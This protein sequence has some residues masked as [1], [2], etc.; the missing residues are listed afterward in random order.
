VVKVNHVSTRD[1]LLQSLI[2]NGQHFVF[3]ADTGSPDNFCTFDVWTRL[4]K[5][6][7][8]PPHSRYTAATGKPLPVRGM[9]YI[10]AKLADSSRSGI[11]EMNVAKCHLNLLGR[12]AIHALGIDVNGLLAKTRSRHPPFSERVCTV[13]PNKPDKALQKACEELCKE[14]PDVFKEELGCLKNFELELKFKPDAKPVFIK[15]RTV[16]LAILEDLDAA[17]EAGIKKGVWELTSFNEWGTP[18]VPVRKPPAPGKSKGD[19]RVCGDYSV[20]INPQLEDHRHPLPLP[21]DLMRK[22]GGGYF[23]T[24]IDLANAYNQIKLGPESQKRLALSTHKGVLLQKRLSFGPKPACSI[25]QELMDKLTRPLRG[26]ATF[27]DDFLVSGT[28]AKDHLQNFRALLQVLRDNGLRA[29]FEKCCFAMPSVE[30]LGHILSHQGIAKGPKVDAVLKMPPPTDVSSLRSFLGSVQFYS[31]FLPNLSTLTE[32][33]IRLTRKDT[34]WT[35]GKEQHDAFRQ[36]KD[37]LSSDT[38]LA[39]YDPSLQIGIST[40]ASEVGIGAVLFHRYRDGSERPIA[41]ASKTLS[42]AQRRY[43]QVQKEALGVI[44]GLKKFH[45]FLFGRQFILITDCKPLVAMFAP[46]KGVPVMAANRLARWALLLSQYDYTVEYRA[47]KDHGNADALSRLPVGDDAIF[48]GEEDREDSNTVC[49]VEGIS[50]QLD[51]V[52]PRLLQKESGKDPI[53]STV[54]RYCKEG[55]PNVLQDSAKPFQKLVDSLSTEN[56]C[57]F[58]GSRIVVPERLRRQV[59][60]LLHL[61]HFGMQRMKQLARSVVYWPHIDDDIERL[62]RECSACQEQQNK[63]PK[64]ANHPWMLPEKPWSRLHVD[65]AI[66][67]M[68]YNW[69][70]LVDAYSKYPCIHPTSSTTAKATMDLLDEDFAHFGYPHTLVSDNATTFLCEEFQAWCKERGITHL[71][72]APYHPATNGAAERLVQSFKQS[73]RKSKLPPKVA[74][75]EF[76]MQYRRTP[77]DSGRSPSE[78]LN[79]RQI[80]TK[81]DALV[82]SPAHVA[83]GRQ[84][85]EAAK[86]Q[87]EETS[88]IVSPVTYYYAVG[89]PCY[90]LYCGP[91]RNKEPRWIPAV[92][93]KVFGSRSV[94]VRVIPRGPTWR[95]HLDQLRPRY[96]TSEDAEPGE[97][98]DIAKSQPPPVAPVPT[99]V[100]PPAIPAKPI[101][102][103]WRLPTTDEYGKHNLRR[104]ARIAAKSGSASGGPSA[105]G[106]VLW[107]RA[108]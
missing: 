92:V 100:Q 104:S 25:F 43:S 91:K 41:Y 10:Q 68:G 22:L 59:L 13:E 39:H 75:R 50:R 80:R 36:L 97:A 79:G 33:L 9:F 94:N 107:T 93:T 35:W 38:V 18:V 101:R 72:G 1:S 44:Y 3:Q 34:P 19:L 52:N 16:P 76:L 54:M 65:H 78:L 12:A 95:R 102:K 23:F 73:L 63:P 66:N 47:T 86:E 87:R 108:M 27:L 105:G 83:Q 11:I 88:H 48:D 67:F 71:S 28:D 21:E 85:K 24:K 51:P 8:Q 49:I 70:V 58:A 2:L 106:E 53:I 90:A 98:P 5:P 61:G 60:D 29:K 31:K 45:H 103:N 7:L 46:T 15:P 4:G 56:G 82:P 81:L 84:A 62:S 14:F 42:P 89:A 74:L 40:D 96:P 32:P 20:T 30:Y 99:N 69:L 64:P 55:W 77:L 37:L 17:Y 57:L 26:T 6:K